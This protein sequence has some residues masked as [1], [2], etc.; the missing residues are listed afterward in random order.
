MKNTK[1]ALAIISALLTVFISSPIIACGN[2]TM[3]HCHCTKKCHCA[4]GQA[5]KCPK[6]KVS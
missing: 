3:K 6:A 5:C 1:W 4:P 2:G